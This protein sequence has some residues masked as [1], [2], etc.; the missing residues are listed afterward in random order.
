MM[1]QIALRPRQTTSPYATHALL[2]TMLHFF[3]LY[4]YILYILYFEYLY[5]FAHCY[6]VPYIRPYIMQ[7]VN[8]LQLL[9]YICQARL[10]LEQSCSILCTCR[11]VCN[12]LTRIH[13]SFCSVTRNPG[14]FKIHAWEHDQ[15]DLVKDSNSISQNMINLICLTIT[16]IS[17]IPK[18]QQNSK[19]PKNSKNDR[20]DLKRARRTDLSARRA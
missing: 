17:K 5:V 10:E 8:I 20:P 4:T 14:H 18:N 7:L 15:L 12:Q 11:H 16:I 1:T 3:N 2:S 19:N 6:T 9:Q 13:N